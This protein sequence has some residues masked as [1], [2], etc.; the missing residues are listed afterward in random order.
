MPPIACAASRSRRIVDPRAEVP[1]HDLQQ[2]RADQRRFVARHR[3]PERRDDGGPVRRLPDREDGPGEVA[4]DLARG[5][6]EHRRDHLRRIHRNV[7]RGEEQLPLGAEIV[8]DQARSRHRLRWPRI[9][10]WSCRSRSVRTVSVPSRGFVTCVRVARTASR[11]RSGVASRVSRMVMA[12][13]LRSWCAPPQRR[14]T[15]RQCEE[16][17]AGDHRQVAPHFAPSPRDGWQPV[18]APR[19]RS[20]AGGRC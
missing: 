5:A 12:G 11:T 17:E 3:R 9:S 1:E 13:R 14:G 18:A 19:P 20:S 15:Q 16:R 7:D 2:E 4:S 6:V 8:V 10:R